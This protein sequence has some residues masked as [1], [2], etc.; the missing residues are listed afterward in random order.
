MEGSSNS[1]FEGVSVSEVEWDMLKANLKERLEKL[2]E[3]QKIIP[4]LMR[5]EITI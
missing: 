2:E 4:D 5:K 1:S 3:A